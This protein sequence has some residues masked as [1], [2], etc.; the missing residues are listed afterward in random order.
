LRKIGEADLLLPYQKLVLDVAAGHFD[1]AYEEVGDIVVV[2]ANE[3]QVAS[4]IQCPMKESSYC[5]SVS[6]FFSKDALESAEFV[7]KSNQVALVSFWSGKEVTRIF[8]CS[9][10]LSIRRL[11][12]SPDSYMVKDVRAWGYQIPV[13]SMYRIPVFHRIKLKG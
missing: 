3:T 4:I 10:G 11:K 9:I 2:S 13:S 6:A 5:D 1:W 8:V 12:I 7:C